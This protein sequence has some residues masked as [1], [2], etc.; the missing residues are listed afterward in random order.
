MKEQLLGNRYD[1]RLEKVVFFK[2]VSQQN[3]LKLRKK[4]MCQRYERLLFF[5]VISTI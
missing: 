5:Y 3:I 1:S 4:L 2:K